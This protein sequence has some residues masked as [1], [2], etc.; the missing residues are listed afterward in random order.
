MAGSYNRWE[1]FNN[2]YNLIFNGV[3]AIPM[4]P[5]AFF[6]LE[7]QK[8]FPD[9]PLLS[10]DMAVWLEVLLVV[11]AVIGITYAQIYKR[12]L[13]Q[14]AKVAGTI[15]EKL[16]RYLQFNIKQYLILT[17]SGVSA[18]IG[19]YLMKDQIFSIL[20]VV[21]LFVFSLSRPTFDR[22]ARETGISEKELT[23]WGNQHD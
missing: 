5:F 18:I 12:G 13:K 7:T 2:R 4:I 1:K 19:L 21:V 23:E 22:T 14:G 11:V 6:F 8:D 10:G 3:I 16:D 17:I 15:D 20:Y 9:P